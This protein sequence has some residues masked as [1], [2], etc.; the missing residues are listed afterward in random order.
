MLFS[1]TRIKR[2]ASDSLADPLRTRALPA[3][4]SN[5][6][7]ARKGRPYVWNGKS[8][9]DQKSSRARCD[10]AAGVNWRTHTRAFECV[11]PRGVAGYSESR[12]QRS[13]RDDPIA[14]IDHGIAPE[15]GCVIRPG[16]IVAV[17]LRAAYSLPRFA[18]RSGYRKN[19]GC[20][21]LMA[22]SSR[23]KT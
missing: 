15:N 8:A 23:S 14:G 17:A 9:R 4:L 13:A 10:S 22:R 11:R 7:G 5:M 12:T 19:L 2:S 21:W 3:D 1:R 20:R 6:A 18:Q 16:Q